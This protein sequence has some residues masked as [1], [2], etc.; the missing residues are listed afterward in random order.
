MLSLLFHKLFCEYFLWHVSHECFSCT[1]Y[2][3]QRIRPQLG[4]F[5]ESPPSR[6]VGLGFR[7]RRE[8]RSWPR[9]QSRGRGWWRRRR[10]RRLHGHL[11]RRFQGCGRQETTTTAAAAAAAATG[12]RGTST[13]SCL[14]IPL[15]GTVAEETSE[16]PSISP[17]PPNCG[18]RIFSIRPFFFNTLR[19]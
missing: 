4:R 11:R 12:G 3:R 17:Y 1:S 16:G 5:T 15:G 2:R 6:R 9:R 8:R 18:F 7:I 14:R 13:V 10:R 19:N